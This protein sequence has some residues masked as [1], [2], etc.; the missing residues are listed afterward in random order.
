MAINDPRDKGQGYSGINR[1]ANPVSSRHNRPGGTADVEEEVD[2]LKIDESRSRG[3]NENA[4]PGSATGHD[5]SSHGEEGGGELSVGDF[6]YTCPRDS[7]GTDKPDMSLMESQ[8]KYEW[9]REVPELNCCRWEE[10]AKDPGYKI[11]KPD[12]QMPMQHNPGMGNTLHEY[13][14]GT[15]HSGSKKGPVV[16]SRAQAI[17]I[18]MS[19]AGKSNR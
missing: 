3:L 9:G 1:S 6:P 4:M 14:T 13:K 18:G 10:F 5:P 15:L 8:L 2:L 7:S 12:A 19:E 16:K 11:A 17:A